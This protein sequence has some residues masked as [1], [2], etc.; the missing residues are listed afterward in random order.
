MIRTQ[1]TMSFFAGLLG[2]MMMSACTDSSTVA[3]SGT[4]ET[5]AAIFWDKDH[6]L[7]NWDLM[8]EY[9]KI[10][11]DESNENVLSGMIYLGKKGVDGLGRAGILHDVTDSVGA[12]ADFSEKQGLCIEY[13]SDFNVEIRLDLGDSVNMSL[14][15]DLPR[16][17]MDRTGEN[18][19]TIC[20]LWSDFKQRDSSLISGSEA[21]SR[22]KSIQI[23]FT[24][25]AG[26]K[27]TFAIT[28]ITAYDDSIVPTISLNFEKNEKTSSSSKAEDDGDSA[29]SSSSEKLSDVV[30]SSS[31]KE[32]VPVVTYGKYVKIV[33]SVPARYEV[34]ENFL[35]DG[36][37]SATPKKVKTG[38]EWDN[39][40]NYWGVISYY[41]FFLK[42]ENGG[43]SYDSVFVPYQ[44]IVGTA[45]LA[46]GAKTTNRPGVGFHVAGDDKHEADISAWG[47]LCLKYKS[48][49]PVV[50]SFY[51]DDKDQKWKATLNSTDQM[52]VAR[53][54]WS[55]FSYYKDQIKQLEN[56]IDQGIG[57]VIDIDIQFDGEG[58]FQI[59]KVG[60][61][62]QCSDESPNQ[63]DSDDSINVVD[64]S[65]AVTYGTF[66]KISPQYR[67]NYVADKNFLWDGTTLDS[68][69][70][71]VTGAEQDSVVNYWYKY[72]TYD[73]FLKTTEE[74]SYDVVFVP[75]VGIAGL[76]YLI[77]GSHSESY[78]GVY[79]MLAGESKRMVDISSWNG[80]CL[81]YESETPVIVE[82]HSVLDSKIPY[83]QVLIN[84]TDSMTV[85]RI[86][87]N[88]FEYSDEEVKNVSIASDVGW[89]TDVLLRFKG[90]GKFRIEQFGAYGMCKE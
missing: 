72:T 84:A 35:W 30:E 40:T 79:L 20:A 75:K 85:A 58:R 60:A 22:V 87:W 50:I 1:R 19:E 28:L 76:A 18:S 31:S 45:V 2:I 5:N 56:P 15:Y 41:D 38:A 3:D 73:Y 66:E 29:E 70:Q 21:A 7:E 71:V 88:A 64:D 33:P 11:F 26:E 8:K 46:N 74:D 4:I 23:M 51:G 43:S 13:Q 86:A 89:A 9:G 67:S 25:D 80:F 78:P 39:A 44:G 83:W 62:G 68:T 36:A 57:R 24:G 55:A 48:E 14:G 90:E 47:G 16:I 77:S 53:V 81:K 6:N 82:L 61:Y 17:V 54:A 65:S 27:G 10:D 49:V 59:E 34:N 63:E 37:A 52:V 32:S 69:K 42:A 12:P